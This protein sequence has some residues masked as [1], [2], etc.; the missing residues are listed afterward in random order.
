MGIVFILKAELSQPQQFLLGGTIFDIFNAALASIYVGLIVTAFQKE[1]WKHRLMP[2]YAVGRMGLTT[3]L[4]QAAIGTLLLFSYG[5]GLLGE[6]GAA[7]WALVGLFVFYL[8]IIFSK[9]W[10]QNFYFGPVEWLWRSL[11]YFKIQPFRKSK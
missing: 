9:L 10:L 2:F 8:Q 1:K 11:T 4:M 6:Y 7:V 5:L 3:Y